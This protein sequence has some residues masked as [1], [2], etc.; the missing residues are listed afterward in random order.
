[1]DNTYTPKAFSI[2]KWGEFPTPGA[3]VEP[4]FGYYSHI[5]Q[6]GT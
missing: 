4:E 3:P 5:Y 6:K 1:M 2:T